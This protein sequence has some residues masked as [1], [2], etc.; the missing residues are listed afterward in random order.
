MEVL[1]KLL[2]K[3]LVKL[4]SGIFLVEQKMLF[5]F[6]TQAAIKICSR[7]VAIPNHL[8]SGQAQGTMPRRA[9]SRN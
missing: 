6:E 4:S 9:K 3:T 8:F 1:Q 5:E 2:N 7:S